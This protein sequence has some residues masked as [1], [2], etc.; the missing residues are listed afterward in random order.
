MKRDQQR[1]AVYDWEVQNVAP[2]D[3]TVVPFAQ[4]ESI[5]HHIWAAEGLEYPPLVVPLPANAK[6]AGKGD[7]TMV[8]F[9]TQT[10]T[11][12]ILHELSHSMTGV[13]DGRTNK[14][15]SLFMGI[16]CQLLNRYLNLPILILAES[17][18]KAG[19]R[20]KLDAKPSF[21]E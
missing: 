21:L 7:R 17:A 8:H 14:H 18:E 20:V 2:Y 15:G 9:P 5:V 1:Q 12:I 13:C 11:W 4:I 10:Y 3:R 19:L 6:I 16:L